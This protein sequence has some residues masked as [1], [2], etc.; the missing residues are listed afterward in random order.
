[1]SD[2]ILAAIDG[3]LQGG[4]RLVILG[5]PNHTNGALYDA[6]HS[7]KD[8]YYRIQV[9]S[10]ET[11]NFRSRKT[12]I[13]GLASY[14]EIMLRRR[15]WGRDG[16][17]Y[18]SHPE[19]QVRVL[20]Q[21][22]SSAENQ[23]VTQWLVD[24]S[25]ERWSAFAGQWLEQ[26][27]ISIEAYH[28]DQRTR[29]RVEALFLDSTDALVLGVD[30]KR[31]GADSMVIQ[32][33]RGA[34]IFVPEEFTG[35]MDGPASAGYVLD[36]VRRYRRGLERVTIIIDRNGLGNSPFDF[37]CQVADK[38]MLDIYGVV[39]GG[40]ARKREDDVPGYRTFRD[41]RAEL[42][43]EVEKRLRD[44]LI[45]QPYQRRRDD[46]LAPRY[47]FGL[48][49]ELVVED[50]QAIRK[51]LGKSCDFYDA[52]ALALAVN[53]DTFTPAPDPGYRAMQRRMPR[54]GANTRGYG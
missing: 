44:D 48:H 14:K 1:M 50:K 15:V 46:L 31:D 37:L 19:Y 53:P 52:L 25:E 54:Y 41:L 34:R 36:V 12:V 4:G 30:P 16:K 43:F 51:R 29:D 40:S 6:F 49:N 26:H 32:P 21:F 3:N 9:S 10:E 18:E 27:G 8:L 24:R 17:G 13:P 35:V 22:P 20:G 33:R 38:E 7:K 11:P 28:E 45:M 23:V 47:R 2:A 39:W 5:N 42:M